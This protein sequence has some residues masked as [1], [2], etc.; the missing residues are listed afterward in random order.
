MN[1]ILAGHAWLKK[2]RSTCNHFSDSGPG[3]QDT[4]DAAGNDHDTS[5]F[6]P[7]SQITT[8]KIRRLSEGPAFDVLT[9]DSYVVDLQADRRNGSA[10]FVV[11]RRSNRRVVNEG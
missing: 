3:T 1:L 7:G 4:H 9:V 10:I 2:R 6:G 11:Y 5:Q 8:Q